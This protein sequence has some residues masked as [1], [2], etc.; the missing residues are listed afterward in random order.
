M[1]GQRYILLAN[2]LGN[3]EHMK[4]VCVGCIHVFLLFCLALTGLEY[5]GVP[6]GGVSKPSHSYRKHSSSRPTDHDLCDPP[7]WLCPAHHYIQVRILK[8]NNT[9]SHSLILL[10]TY[11]FVMCCSFQST[12][13]CT[14]MY[15]NRCHLHS[16]M[17]K[18]VCVCVC[19][20]FAP[21][22]LLYFNFPDVLL[23][24]DHTE[25]KTGMTIVSA[26]WNLPPTNNRFL[27]IFEI[28]NQ[29][30]CE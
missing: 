18:C 1:R 12:H 13:L 27:F 16:P 23:H 4:F 24:T 28:A 5:G 29:F 21:C 25:C 2:N 6:G 30:R 10:L 26:T 19:V 22:P 17:S 9:H 11:V 8:R 3:A 14:W 15:N 7:H 20:C